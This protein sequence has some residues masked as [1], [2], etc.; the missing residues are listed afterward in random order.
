MTK[1]IF[2]ISVSLDGFVSGP[3]HSVEKIFQ[4]Y[5]QGDT[6]FQFPGLEYTFKVSKESAKHLS[7]YSATVGAMV[8]GHTNFN[9]A[10][11]WGGS[12]PLG[13]PHIVMAHQPPKE[14]T[15]PGSPFTFIADDIEKA[16]AI[17]KEKAN[18]KDVCISSPSV[19]QQFLNKGLVDELY[20]DLVDVFLGEGVRL[21]ENLQALPELKC[22]TVIR[23][24]GVTHLGYQVIK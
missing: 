22:T 23:G 7:R 1:V 11:A 20:L 5:G 15:G 3:N 12:P 17:A 13:V 18:G 19:L 6:D 2:N 21:F 9:L 16:L 4:W 24:T 8:T 14:W 10:Q